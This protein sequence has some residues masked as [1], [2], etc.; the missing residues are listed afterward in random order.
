MSRQPMREHI[1]LRIAANRKRLEQARERDDREQ[2]ILRE[3]AQQKEQVK[4]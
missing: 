3:M 4:K 1:N 2:R